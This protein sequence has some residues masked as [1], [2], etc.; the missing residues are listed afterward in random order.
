MELKEPAD[1][2]FFNITI[3]K[4]KA[5]AIAIYQSKIIDLGSIPYIFSNYRGFQDFNAQGNK[6]GMLTKEEISTGNSA[7]GLVVYVGDY[8]VDQSI[9]WEIVNGKCITKHEELLDPNW[10]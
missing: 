6:L 5:E 7:N 3:P 4:Q 8:P 2:V 9:I 10:D 1:W